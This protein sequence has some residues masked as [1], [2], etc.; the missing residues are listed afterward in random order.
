[1]NQLQIDTKMLEDHTGNFAVC[2]DTSSRFNGWLFYRHADGQWVTQRLALPM[3][4]LRAQA[5]L[6]RLQEEAGIPQ[7]G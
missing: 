1:M 5:K 6:Q 4:I 7:K 2:L 3:E